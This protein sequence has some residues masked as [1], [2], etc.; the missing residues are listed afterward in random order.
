[1]IIPLI[2]RQIPDGLWQSLITIV[3]NTL[4]TGLS[5][6]ALILISRALGPTRFGEF[7]V[8]FAIIMILNKINDA[9]LNAT[10]LKFVPPALDDQEKVNRFFS[11]TFKLK[12]IIAAFILVLG[13][14]FTPWLSSVLHFSQPVIILLAFT[15][16]FASTVYEQLLSMLQSLHRFSEAVVVNALQSATKL[17]GALALSFLAFSNDVTIFSFYMLAPVVPLVCTRW[18]LPKW[19][20]L[21]LRNNFEGEK[22]LVLNMAKH[23]AIGFIAAGLI[24]NID[25]LFIQ[26][27]LSSYETGLMAGVSKIAAMVVLIAYSLG[28]VLYPRVARYQTREHLTQYLKKSFLLIIVT[29]IGFLAF[30]PLARLSILLTIGPEYLAGTEVLTILV[31]G[32]FLTIATIPFLA[33][34]YAF[35][36][37]WYFSVSGILQLLIVVVGNITL[38]PEYGLVAS[39]WTRL[40]MRAF[41]FIFTATLGL[42]LYH[43]KYHRSSS[44]V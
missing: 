13:I 40:G 33:L 30:L 34:F 39:A 44:A 11:Y 19:V 37:N 6:I 38:V 43:Q 28:N 26:R 41:L 1:M 15:L 36:A 10:L 16:S 23:T 20:Q 8:G 3:G 42:W 21:K 29:V 14:G 12:L 4:A 27:Y 35:K 24:E 17:V 31:A 22:K 32:S 9:G 5:A 18:L 7:S 25:L 2:K